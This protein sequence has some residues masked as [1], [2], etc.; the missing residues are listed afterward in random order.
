M[1]SFRP[2]PSAD[3]PW[4][5]RFREQFGKLRGGWHPHST[6]PHDGGGVVR[7]RVGECYGGQSQRKDEIIWR[8]RHRAGL[9]FFLDQ[10]DMR[11]PGWFIVAGCLAGALSEILHQVCQSS[12]SLCVSV[13]RHVDGPR[14]W[15][16]NDVGVEAS[17]DLPQARRHGWKLGRG[18]GKGG[19]P[20]SDWHMVGAWRVR[21]HLWSDKHS[22]GR[23]PQGLTITLHAGMWQT[24]FADCF[25]R[26]FVRDLCLF[27][28]TLTCRF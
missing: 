24:Q 26:W 10:I 28:P 19:S 17:A 6:Q 23:R 20:D 16:F 13:Y 12:N 9:S 21:W 5:A 25:S 18:G 2:L 3:L 22:G 4:L 14:W 1:P 27:T 15:G 7:V 11:L 8:G